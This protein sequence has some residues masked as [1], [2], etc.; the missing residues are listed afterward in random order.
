MKVLLSIIRK[1]D[2]LEIIKY[3]DNTYEITAGYGEVSELNR[4]AMLELLNVLKKE[5]ENE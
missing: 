2:S 4:E 1:P 5:F 3:N